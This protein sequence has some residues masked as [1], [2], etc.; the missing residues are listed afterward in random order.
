LVSINGIG[1]GQVGSLPA[2]AQISVTVNNA[3]VPTSGSVT[4][5]FSVDGGQA[6][7]ESNETNNTFS[8]TI[9]V[10]SASTIVAA[11]ILSTYTWYADDPTTWPTVYSSGSITGTQAL[12]VK[13][14]DGSQY[15]S[16][17]LGATS[18]KITGTSPA[19]TTQLILYVWDYATNNYASDQKTVNIN[20]TNKGVVISTQSCGGSQPTGSGVS[21]GNGTY[22]TGYGT[23]QW[24]FVTGTP[25]ACQ[26]TCQSGYGLSGNGCAVV[27]TVPPTYPTTQACGG[28]QPASNGYTQVGNG[29]YSTGYG[30]TQWTFVTGTPNACQFTCTNNGMYNGVTCIAPST[31][32]MQAPNL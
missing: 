8:K 19:G 32:S 23:T 22:T 15:F 1:S 12:R 26:W 21:L 18:G 13:G 11:P 4:V 3:F 10:S 27:G 25:A 9:S 14:L 24:T 29:F 6:V 30:T 5:N 7:S 20:V 17:N 16:L 31:N 28:T 2:G